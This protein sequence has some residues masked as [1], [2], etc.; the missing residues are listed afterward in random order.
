MPPTF[1]ASCGWDRPRAARRSL[2]LSPRVLAPSVFIRVVYKKNWWLNKTSCNLQFQQVFL[3]TACK[4]SCLVLPVGTGTATRM[5]EIRKT[6]I[7]ALRQAIRN[8][9]RSQVAT[10]RAV[11]VSPQAVSEILRRGRRVPAGWGLALEKATGI[12]RAAGR[13]RG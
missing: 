11:G 5:P 7:G 9:L 6:G 3:L 1:L 12:G 10:A 4:C 2:T 8:H 13:G